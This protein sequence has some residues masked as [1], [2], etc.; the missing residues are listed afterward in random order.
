[1]LKTAATG[2]AEL[3]I[4]ADPR[5]ATAYLRQMVETRLADGNVSSQE[6]K[7]LLLYAKRMKLSDAD[8]KL[9][10]VR[11]RKA[12]FQA[13]KDLLRKTKRSTA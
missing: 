7:L 6:R 1:M 9:E 8:V 13:A 3:P 5:E 10:I 11:Q 12:R 2:D 4:P